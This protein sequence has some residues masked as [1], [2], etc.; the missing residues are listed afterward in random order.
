MKEALTFLKKKV[1]GLLKGYPVWAISLAITGLSALLLLPYLATEAQNP[2]GL[3]ILMGV[4][5]H[6]MIHPPGNPLYMALNQCA[7]YFVPSIQTISFLSWVYFTAAAILIFFTAQHLTKSFFLAI[8][9]VLL[10]LTY[11][12]A[13]SLGT[14][15]EKYSF[16]YLIT[17]L[18]FYFFRR[19]NFYGICT[20]LGLAAAHHDS[21]VLLVF[22]LPLAFSFAASKRQIIKGLL[23]ALLIPLLAYSTFFFAAPTPLWPNQGPVHSLRELMT[24]VTF[25]GFG[26]SARVD[27][28]SLTQIFT[29]SFFKTWIAQGLAA[30]T[31]LGFILLIMGIFSYRQHPLRRMTL[32]LTIYLLSGIVVL[33]LGDLPDTDYG[34][35][36][37]VRYHTILLIPAL[38]LMALGVP[39]TISFL[40]KLTA[41]LTACWPGKKRLK[42]APTGKI[43]PVILGTI[44]FLLPGLS[45][46]T[47]REII[48]AQQNQ[49][50]TT[51][52]NI[53]A[54][55]ISPHYLWAEQTDYLVFGGI[56][57]KTTPRTA[58]YAEELPLSFLSPDA[59]WHLPHRFPLFPA[60]LLPLH[61]EEKA[62]TLDPYFAQ[63]LPAF[64]DRNYSFF[65]MLDILQRQ[66]VP[67]Q[68]ADPEVAVRYPRFREGISMKIPPPSEVRQ[69]VY[70]RLTVAYNQNIADR[71]CQGLAH[72]KSKVP[73]EQS[74]F[75][76]ILLLD[77][78][79][80]FLEY[81][82]LWQTI[83]SQDPTLKAINLTLKKLSA[84]IVAGVSP[85]IW[86]TLCQELSQEAAQL[87][88]RINQ[89][90]FELKD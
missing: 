63:A 2:D 79:K 90:R 80:F 13:A 71:L 33:S 48:Y 87:G 20:A 21:F 15:P 47:A 42:R 16:L 78:Q 24:F 68:T 56:P 3:E 70:P 34:H 28:S 67:I 49:I 60:L 83:P 5:Y 77:W 22:L 76:K 12:A 4:K 38:F 85:H 9:I 86:H 74:Y 54:A 29:H 52:Q 51:W 7:A 44:I 8:W 69:Q 58:K 10:F 66:G 53:L 65:Q 57:I 30:W 82:L 46:L 45:Y 39:Q 32:A 59:T 14:S 36:Y 41:Y 73:V 40:N 84:T 26:Q 18:F 62:A 37:L 6:T 61:G 17:A 89:L 88:P 11:P 19:K 64:L 72:I 31:V 1:I 27:W 55:E 50:L 25:R 43:I 81:H 75:Q 23:L 35:G